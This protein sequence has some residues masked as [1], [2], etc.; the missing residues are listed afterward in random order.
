MS[1]QNVSKL[2]LE[3]LRLIDALPHFPEPLIQLESM[4]STGDVPHMDTLSALILKDPRLTSG[5]IFSANTA[6]Y[7]D[8]GSVDCVEKAV[9]RIGLSDVRLL[10]N[11]I[12]LEK[13]LTKKSLLEE[14]VF[15]QHAFVT[16]FMAKQ[17]AKQSGKEASLSFLAGLMSSIGIYLLI[18][19]DE[20]KY[21]KVVKLVEKKQ[22]LLSQ[23][24]MKITESSYPAVGARMLQQWKFPVAV[25]MA[26][27]GQ[28]APQ[29]MNEKFQ[30][31]AYVVQL[32]SI[33]SCEN[34]F[35]LGLKGLD[36]LVQLEKQEEAK[37]K[38]MTY[39]GLDDEGILNKV[40]EQA[41]EQA[42]LSGFI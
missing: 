30:D 27:A 20:K 31:V 16:G 3:R 40:V 25:I 24:E 34:G 13:V 10:L 41:L 35:E 28:T 36:G 12:S 9:S 29:S 38:A 21:Q 4:L 23:A 6:K 42:K 18:S 32:A 2:I 14:K 7:C 33:L 39:L 15:M 37:A 26:V 1:S 8:S 22:M 11:A 19:D 17:I 5:V